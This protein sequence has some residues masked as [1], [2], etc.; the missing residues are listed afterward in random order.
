[1][2]K[3][4]TY[5]NLKCAWTKISFLLSIL[6]HMDRFFNNRGMSI[7]ILTTMNADNNRIIAVS[8]RLPVNTPLKNM[9][10]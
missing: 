8:M 6:W 4:L 3:W 10:V 1:M 7:N 2:A 5:L 9:T